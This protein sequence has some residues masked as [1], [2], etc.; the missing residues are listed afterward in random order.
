MILVDLI[1]RPKNKDLPGIK[2]LNETISLSRLIFSPLCIIFEKTSS[3]LP[4][5][6]LS[7]GI[8]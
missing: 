4:I 3:N 2:F 8:I 5:S 7:V 1:S 6:E